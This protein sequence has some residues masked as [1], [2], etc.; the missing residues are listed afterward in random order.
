MALGPDDS[1]PFTNAAMI[2]EKATGVLVVESW[3]RYGKLGVASPAF[4]L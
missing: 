1:H 2:Q 4:H 3:F